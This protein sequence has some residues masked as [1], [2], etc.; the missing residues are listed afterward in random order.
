VQKSVLLEI[1][2]LQVS[3]AAQMSRA[4]QAIA[5]L[6]PVTRHAICS[7]QPAHEQQLDGALI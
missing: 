6:L 3:A 2:L 1:G 5:T 4:T 7:K